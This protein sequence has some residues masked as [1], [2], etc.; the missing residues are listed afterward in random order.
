MFSFLSNTSGQTCHEIKGVSAPLCVYVLVRTVRTGLGVW[1]AGVRTGE[2]G[3]LV[4]VT[5]G[6]SF[7]TFARPPHICM[8]HVY[9]RRITHERLWIQMVSF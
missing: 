3:T 8:W 9:M 4:C 6:V 2:H 5:V 7:V 1:R